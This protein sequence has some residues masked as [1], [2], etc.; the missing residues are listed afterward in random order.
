M[1]TKRT[2]RE[3]KEQL[4]EAQAGTRQRRLNHADVDRAVDAYRGWQSSIKRRDLPLDAATVS[5][6]M[7]GGGVSRSYDYPASSTYLSVSS[8]GIW[9]RRANTSNHEGYYI[10]VHATGDQPYTTLPTITAGGRVW[11]AYYRWGGETRY[12]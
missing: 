8:D 10:S 1:I 9:A 6:E 4:D 2:I 3:A 7:Y 5:V 12:R 11:G